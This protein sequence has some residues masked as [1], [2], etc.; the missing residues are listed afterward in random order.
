MPL[1]PAMS[2]Q[3]ISAGMS[4]MKI[5]EI[6]RIARMVRP[7]ERDRAVA[8]M[9]APRAASSSGD[10]PDPP[11]AADG[12]AARRASRPSATRSTRF[13]PST[14]CRFEP[15]AMAAMTPSVA[16]RSSSATDESD[17]PSTRRRVMQFSTSAMFAE[18]PTASRICWAS[19][20]ASG[21]ACSSGERKRKRGTSSTARRATSRQQLRGEHGRRQ[22][23]HRS[24]SRRWRS[25][26][27]RPRRRV[28][29]GPR[30]GER[31]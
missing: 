8:L 13:G 11:T 22:R 23:R 21:M 9:D 4:G 14:I 19:C 20:C 7:S 12:A 17:T 30:R 6:F 29:P 31:R 18:P 16:L 27:R 10:A 28:P 2:P 26:P 15:A 3:A 5:A 1:I 25:S 24:G